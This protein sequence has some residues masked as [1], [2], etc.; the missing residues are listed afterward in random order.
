[1]E[2]HHLVLREFLRNGILLMHSYGSLQSAPK[3]LLI[4]LH[5]NLEI[6][7]RKWDIFCV[8]WPEE[9]LLSAGNIA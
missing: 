1:M 9:C 4:T 2:F 8:S 5:S 3:L 7:I 6:S